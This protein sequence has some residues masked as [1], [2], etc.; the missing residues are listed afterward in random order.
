[1]HTRIIG[2]IGG[3]DPNG[4]CGSNLAAVVFAA[5]G[6]GDNSAEGVCLTR[7]LLSSK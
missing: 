2:I 4:T 1:M 3:A 7:L 5:D 6:A